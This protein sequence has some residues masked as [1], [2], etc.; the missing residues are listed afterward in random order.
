MPN[1]P[2]PSVR[3]RDPFGYCYHDDPFTKVTLPDL[4][5]PEPHFDLTHQVGICEF[6]DY[7]KMEL[8]KMLYSSGFYSAIT[9][10]NI[11]LGEDNESY[12]PFM[13]KVR[14]PVEIDYTIPPHERIR[15]QDHITYK[16]M[17][18]CNK[19]LYGHCCA[20]MKF[21]VKCE[22]TI[23]APP[24][25]LEF[26]LEYN[27]NKEENTMMT[28]PEVKEII[29]RTSKRGEFFTVKW[30]DNTQTTVKRMEGDVSD[31]YTAFLYALGKK[32]FGD[33]GAARKYIT[34]KKQVFETR[35]EKE[36]TDHRRQRRE[37]ALEQSLRAEGYEPLDD[38]EL[39]AVVYAQGM[40]PAA[41]F[42][43]TGRPNRLKKSTTVPTLGPGKPVKKAPTN[44]PEVSE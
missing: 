37:A 30:A 33:K 32:L 18:L 38:D 22:V 16:M 36:A 40:V 13:M 20:Y 4:P 43:S 17:E 23:K 6:F 35:V 21:D 1:I 11:V 25:Q 26:K 41:L 9:I 10:G 24:Q 34:D 29:H 31:E 5:E 27:E 39:S 44:K 19:Y 28:I 2:V 3:V 12:D 14:V 15:V 8:E 42:M 7:M